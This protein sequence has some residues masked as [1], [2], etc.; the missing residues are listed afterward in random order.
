MRRLA[1]LL[2]LLCSV[3]AAAQTEVR[4]GAKIRIDAP[5]IV[6]DHLVGTVLTRTADTLVVGGPEVAP[7]SISIARITSLEVSHG[8]S[9][10]A[11]AI[12]GLQWGG[13]IGFGLGL[14]FIP[15]LSCPGSTGTSSYCND[16]S[17]SDKALFVW[18]LTASGLFYG[19]IIGAIAGKEEWDRFDLVP[20][21]SLQMRNGRPALAL[22]F[23]L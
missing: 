16:A 11:G 2:P 21:A 8:K 7:I 4:P 5:G 3:R 13:G 15:L 19:S 18:V 22:S 9:H 1:L 10:S 12:K 17:S 14:A 20:R 6:A 23:A